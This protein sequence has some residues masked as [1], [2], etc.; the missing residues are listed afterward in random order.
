MSPAQRKRVLAAIPANWCDPLLS[1][2]ENVLSPEPVN[3]PQIDRLLAAVRA[4]V[5]LALPKK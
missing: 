1:G 3:C 2:K 4:R 5:K